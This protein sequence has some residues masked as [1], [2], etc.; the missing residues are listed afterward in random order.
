M[1]LT[2]LDEQR[3]AKVLD[4]CLGLPEARAVPTGYFKSDTTFFVRKKKFAYHLV[5]VD[6][7]G[8]VQLNVRAAP[9]SNQALIESDPERFF[10]PGYIGMHGWVGIQLDLPTIDWSQI[11]E[12]LV[13]SY[14][15]Q[16]PKTL[17]RQLEAF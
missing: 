16:A 17:V 2:P 5:D 11:G 8:R 12:M 14:T 4:I 15:L 7:D 6:H 3:Y 10:W 1:R 9:G 13:A